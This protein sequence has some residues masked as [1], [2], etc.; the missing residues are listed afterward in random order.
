MQFGVDI[1]LELYCVN[2][3]G[4]TS[5]TT[6]GTSLSIRNK[7]LLSIQI[8]PALTASGIYFLLTSLPAQ[9]KAISISYFAKSNTAK[10]LTVICLFIDI[11]TFFPDD[12][13]DAKAY[14]FFIGNFLSSKIVN[15]SLPT[16]P[17]A[18]TTAMLYS[19][20]TIAKFVII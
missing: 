9:K 13:K 1:I 5:G 19:L 18:P 6:K 10:S 12:C 15:T 14:M 11:E 8:H 17:V 4:L 3:S 7:E 20:F 2:A 16:F